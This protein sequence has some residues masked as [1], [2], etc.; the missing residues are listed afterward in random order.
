[1]AMVLVVA[2]GAGSQGARELSEAAANRAPLPLACR[3]LAAHPPADR[4]VRLTGAS[5]AVQ[6]G[7]VRFTKGVPDRL[8]VPLTCG[9]SPTEP[10]RIVLATEEEGLVWPFVTM[11]VPTDARDSTVILP[12]ASATSVRV[13]R[14]L[15]GMVRTSKD[16]E[17]KTTIGGGLEGGGCLYCPVKIQRLAADYV[18]LEEGAAPSPLRGLAWLAGAGV[19]IVFVGKRL[20]ASPPAVM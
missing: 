1:A 14:D 16:H 20:G 4:W 19:G 10:V 9:D 5:G 6:S 18:V 15:L 8:Y 12:V 2:C 7:A 17:T 3:E 13:R 11:N